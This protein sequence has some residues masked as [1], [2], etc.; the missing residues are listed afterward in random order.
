MLG[1]F[2]DDGFDFVLGEEFF[3]YQVL[4]FWKRLPKN[5]PLAFLLL[6]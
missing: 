1:A 4:E 2:F 6:Y 5:K 3:C